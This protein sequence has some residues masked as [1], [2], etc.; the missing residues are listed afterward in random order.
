MAVERPEPGTFIALL[1]DGDRDALLALG[2][3]RR[4][5]PREHLMHEGEPGDRVLVLERGHVKASSTDSRGRATVLAFRGP[6][7]ILGELTF[8]NVAPRSGDVIA[9][10]R[11]EARALAASEFCAYLLRHPTAAMTLIE[12][13]GRRVR[14]GDRKRAQFGDLDTV[15]RIAA[16]MVELCERYGER[17]DGAIAIR[18]PITQADLGGW[19]GSSSGAVDSA[20]RTMR[21]LGWIK[22][23]RRRITVTD[24]DALQRRAYAARERERE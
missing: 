23:E 5:A 15:G 9:L 11:V 4:F 13:I 16:R 21:E 19:T 1:S 24:L 8:T 3:V 12:A 17:S 10:E 20:L 18:L 14:D 7:D 6:G 22:T 2:G